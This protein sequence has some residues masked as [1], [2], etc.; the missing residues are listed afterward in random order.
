M[1]QAKAMTL[2][3]HRRAARILAP[4][5]RASEVKLF[6][7]RAHRALGAGGSSFC[8]VQFG[9]ATAFPHGLPEDQA[10]EEDQLVLIDTGCTI[11]GYHSDITRTYAF[12]AVDRS[13]EHTSELQSLIRISYA[14]L[15]LKKKNI[16]KQQ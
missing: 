16:K 8:A 6:I 12:G 7:D 2:E 1:G 11:E 5:I 15:C 9:R 10:L 4:G 13:E 3:V 14:V